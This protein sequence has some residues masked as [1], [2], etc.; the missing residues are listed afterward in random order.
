MD[1][2]NDNHILKWIANCY[3]NEVDYDIFNKD[4]DGTGGN[5]IGRWRME[6]NERVLVPVE[7]KNDHKLFAKSGR[8]KAMITKNN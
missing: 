5:D 6:I 7:N 3:G 4:H 8:T 1:R 2:T